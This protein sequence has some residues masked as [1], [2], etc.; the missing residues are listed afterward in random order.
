MIWHLALVLYSDNIWW[1]ILRSNYYSL[2]THSS[3]WLSNT[4]NSPDLLWGVT[5]PGSRVQLRKP[6]E[7]QPTPQL[8]FASLKAICCYDPFTLWKFISWVQFPFNQWPTKWNYVAI[9][10]FEMIRNGLKNAHSSVKILQ[11]IVKTEGP[12]HTRILT[13]KWE[14]GLFF[15]QPLAWAHS[16][17]TVSNLS[18]WIFIYLFFALMLQ[19]MGKQIYLHKTWSF[20]DRTDFFM[21]N[22]SGWSLKKLYENPTLKIN[23]GQQMF[24]K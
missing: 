24:S 9:F 7:K 20:Q 6:G 10:K 4:P 14:M 17:Q 18:L 12:P 1:F 2:T 19:W 3:L 23:S 15:L 13:E 22:W 8:F 21:G 16:K 5:F 11:L